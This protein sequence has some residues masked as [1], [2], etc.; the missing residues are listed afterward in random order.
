MKTASKV[1][2]YDNDCLLCKTYTGA[3]VKT[4]LLP[5]SGRQHFNTVD[6]EIFKLVDQQLCNNEIPLVDIA[7]QKVWYGIDAMLEIL[8]ARFPFIKRWGSLQPIKWILK[9]G[10]KIISYNRKVIVAKAPPA[11]YDC[12][13]NFHLRYRILFIGI[14][15]GFH[16]MILPVLYQIVFQQMETANLKILHL[17][18]IFAVLVFVS[19]LLLVLTGIKK[20]MEAVGQIVMTTTIGL[21]CMIPLLII[22]NVFGQLPAV[23]VYVYSGAVLVST[24]KEGNRRTR[25]WNSIKKRL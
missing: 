22:T 10:Y 17:A 4:G 9:K 13:P 2:I 5:A 20:G 11:G 7:E 18:A 3:F 19:A 1:L 16:W 12:S 14:L 15:L 21:L 23:F 25:Y 6:P 8:G 24:V